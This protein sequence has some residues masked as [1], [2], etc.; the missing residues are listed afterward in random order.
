MRQSDKVTES[1]YPAEGS[2]TE[3]DGWR[4]HSVQ[5]GQGRDV[6]LIHGAGGSTRDMTFR[7]LPRLISGRDALRVTAIDRPGHGYTTSLMQEL[8][9]SPLE[10][11]ELLWRFCDVRGIDAPIILGQS[12]GGAVA[13]AMELLRPGRASSL[14]LVSAACTDAIP[15]S[16]QGMEMIMR[17]DMIRNSALATIASDLFIDMALG[18]LFSPEPIPE[19]YAAH[20][21]P[22]MSLRD[23]SFHHCMSQVSSL[24]PTLRRMTPHYARIKTPVEILHGNRDDILNHDKHGAWLSRA[25]PGAR[26]TSLPGAGHMPHQTRVDDVAN[27]VFRLS[28]R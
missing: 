14:C 25:I 19:G 10:Q 4:M 1:L 13:L 11:A 24:G 22:K 9:I 18:K 6:L 21:G 27:A 5:E 3:V 23:H 8:V 26:F 16:A 15:S 20:F 17:L 12:F 7:L 28:R 2:F